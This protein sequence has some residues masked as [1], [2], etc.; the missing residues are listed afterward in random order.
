MF[1]RPV[2]SICRVLE[3]IRVAVTWRLGIMRG[4]GTG[5]TPDVVIDC[6]TYGQDYGGFVLGVAGLS[7]HCVVYSFGVGCDISFD[8]DMIEKWHANVYAFDPTPKSLTWLNEQSLPQEFRIFPYALGAHDGM[9]QF[10]PPSDPTH[11]SHSIAVKKAK[12]LPS[13]E[14]RVRRLQT[15]V[16]EL[17]HKQIDVLKMDIEGAE[18][19]VL[20]D[21]L[22]TDVDIRQIVL[23]FHHRYFRFGTLKT[24]LAVRRLRAAGFLLFHVS[25][26]SL[27]FGFIRADVLDDNLGPR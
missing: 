14:V 24:R 26:D 1:S 22:K 15:I 8:L 25:E 20:Q 4:W 23:E 6:E 18:Y 7:D 10:Y 19:Q 9:A 13:E 21:I 12:N 27:D 3:R 5:E 2:K 11:V 16:D 17:G